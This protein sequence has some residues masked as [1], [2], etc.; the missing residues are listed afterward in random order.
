M[1][2]SYVEEYLF[3][4]L[5]EFKYGWYMTVF[6]LTCF[7]SFAALERLVSSVHSF[8]FANP[9]V[10]SIVDGFDNDIN[11]PVVKMY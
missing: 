5:P 11:S 9:T 1:L 2:C 8:V 7:S 4:E 6:E 10:C 3:Q